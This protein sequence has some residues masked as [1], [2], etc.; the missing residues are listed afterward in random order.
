MKDIT[1][2]GIPKVMESF[3][4]NIWCIGNCS[5]PDGRKMTIYIFEET[6]PDLE[7]NQCDSTHFY[8]YTYEPRDSC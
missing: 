8:T 4:I 5:A 2:V 3:Y 7:Q 6:Y 1:R